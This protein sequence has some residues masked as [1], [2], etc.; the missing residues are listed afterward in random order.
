M[1][2]PPS[3]FAPMHRAHLWIDQQTTCLR[4][5][6]VDTCMGLVKLNSTPNT[7]IISTADTLV[8]CLVEHFA[9]VLFS[10]FF[11]FCHI[12]FFSGFYLVVACLVPHGTWTDFSPISDSSYK[13]FWLFAS[14]EERGCDRRGWTSTH[15]GTFTF[16]NEAS[17]WPD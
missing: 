16:L 4:F 17:W 11:F 13:R 7:S 12:L 2:P 9:W 8:A 3:N 15:Y 6:V 10:S 1:I 14:S 5:G